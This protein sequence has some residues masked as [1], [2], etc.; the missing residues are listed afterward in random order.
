MTGRRGRSPK[1]SSGAGSGQVLVRGT[2]TAAL[3]LS[4][5]ATGR[6]IDYA[7]GR[8]DLGLSVV[9]VGTLLDGRKVAHLLEV[10]KVPVE[11]SRGDISG[12]TATGALAKLA[13]ANQNVELY[14]I[15]DLSFV[16]LEPTSRYQKPM[17]S[18]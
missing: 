10:V 5:A 14:L 8:A 15:I 13:Q 11:I 17:V 4:V 12:Q 9:A 16:S 7:T 18:I 6:T 1:P 3:A 2:G